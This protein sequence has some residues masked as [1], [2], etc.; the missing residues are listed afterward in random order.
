MVLAFNPK[1]QEAELQASPVYI[2]RFRPAGP[3]K[4]ESYVTTTASTTASTSAS[5]TSTTAST[6]STTTSTY[7]ISCPFNPYCFAQIFVDH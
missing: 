4:S 6:T 3:T 7:S 1:A 2:V 5:T